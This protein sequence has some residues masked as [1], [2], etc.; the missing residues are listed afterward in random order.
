[1]LFDIRGGTTFCEYIYDNYKDYIT[2]EHISYFNNIYDVNTAKDVRDSIFDT[3]KQF[4]FIEFDVPKNKKKG[5][6]LTITINKT[7]RK[8]APSGFSGK[9]IK[10]T[11]SKDLKPD[12]KFK[13]VLVPFDFLMYI[14]MRM[15]GSS[16]YNDKHMIKCK[17]SISSC[18]YAMWEGDMGTDWNCESYITSNSGKQCLPL[19]KPAGLRSELDGVHEHNIIYTGKFNPLSDDSMLGSKPEWMGSALCVPQGEG[20][21]EVG[22]NTAALKDC[23]GSTWCELFDDM[24]LCTDDYCKCDAL[25]N[26]KLEYYSIYYKYWSQTKKEKYKGLE[27][28]IFNRYNDPLKI[29]GVNIFLK[30]LKSDD[31][32]IYNNIYK[33]DLIE[34][35]LTIDRDVIYNM[36]D[37]KSKS[38]SESNLKFTDVEDLLLNHVRNRT[39][40]KKINK[41]SPSNNLEIYIKCIEALLIY[42]SNIDG[43][44]NQINAIFK[45][46]N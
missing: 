4:K 7:T 32:D 41:F 26:R 38:G 29:L 2:R 31:M 3:N 22:V 44:M 11:F 25:L 33:K 13:T 12:D 23:K 43:L 1:M 36:P 39:N 16:I 20:I 19:K 37:P 14:A 18:K 28:E 21:M 8:V 46:N 10:I 17:H 34:L 30:M 9:T 27:T 5:Q 24:T 40:F 45:W 42:H 6:E 15:D 35:S